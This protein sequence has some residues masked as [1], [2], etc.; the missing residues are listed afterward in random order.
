MKVFISSCDT[1]E[2]IPGALQE[3]VEKLRH[4]H[5]LSDKTHTL[6]DDPESADI[7]LVVVVREDPG[8]KRYLGH[9]LINKYPGKCFSISDADHPFVLHHGIYA[10][11]TQSL[12]AAGRIRCGAFTA[13]NDR[14][15]NPYVQAHVPSPLDSLKKKFLL[16]F[17]GRNCCH[18]RTL[19]FRLKFERPDIFIEDSSQFNLWL[20]PEAGRRERQKHYYETLLSSKFS[21]CPRGDGA[22][23]LRLFES[24]QLG[25]APVIISDGWIFPKGPRWQDFSIIL[26][27][28]QLG[29]LEKI[30]ET[31]ENSY[32]AMGSLARKAFDGYFAERLYFGYIVAN[33]VDVMRTQR[34]PEAFYWKLNPSILAFRRA[35]ARVF[36]LA[37]RALARLVL[38]VFRPR[39]SPP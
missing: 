38:D 26:K 2:G 17:V 33:C 10:S 8:A 24:M 4:L 28:K 7:I 14:F 19:I 37:Q 16:S 11:G 25:V 30:V 18:L 21:L 1:G 39:E 36:H 32:A 23:S 5:E 15:L 3:K 27:Q 22:S 9:D 12:L 34:I 31:H 20:G 13:Y 29:D 6:V 35:R